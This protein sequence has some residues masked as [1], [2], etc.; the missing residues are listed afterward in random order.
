MPRA[1][2]LR[3][4]RKRFVAGVSGCLASADV[5]RGIDLDVDAGECVAIVG[6]A[7]CGKS[8]LLLC[9]AGLLHLDTGSIAWF[10]DPT[11]FSAAARTHYAFSASELTS[12]HRMADGQVYLLDQPPT[13]VVDAALAGWISDRCE[14]GSAVVIA[15]RDERAVHRWVDRVL[16]LS[17]GVLH[18]AR[19]P[20]MRVAESMAGEA[21]PFC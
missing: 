12:H 2:Q 4:V 14:C 20:G 3:G 1:L 10:G 7:G 11:P 19:A 5:L 13:A 16:V 21:S 8:T 6:P 17:G 15:A 9:A 18:F